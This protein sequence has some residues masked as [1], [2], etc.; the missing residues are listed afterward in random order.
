MVKQP[1]KAR[2]WYGPVVNKNQAGLI[3]GWASWPMIVFGTF[4]TL[5]NL[6]RDSGTYDQYLDVFIL[7][8]IVVPALILMVRK[9]QD[10]RHMAFRALRL[11]DDSNPGVWSLRSSEWQ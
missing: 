6:S 11:H 5:S 10:C 2:F 4:G 9:K 3:I 1:A 8:M 7:L